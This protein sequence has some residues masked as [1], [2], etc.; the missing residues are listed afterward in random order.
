VANETQDTP[1]EHDS[2]DDPENYVGA[3]FEQAP[4]WSTPKVV[5]LVAVVAVLG[6]V[7]ALMLQPRFDTPAQD[8]AD[9]GFLQDMIDHHE[10]AVQLGLVASDSATDHTVKHFGIEAIV[11]QQYEVGYM[12]SLLEDWGY[13]TGDADR[14]AMAWMG[15]PTSVEQMPGMAS[16]QEMA[17][18]RKSTG[19]DVDIT[20]MRLMIAHHRGGVHMA[21]DA[22]ANATDERV[23]ALAARMAKNQRAEIAEYEA[24]AEKLGF[25]L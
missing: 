7:L 11:A 18:F 10:Q 19:S 17:E 6:V 12:T 5:G 2:S 16:T 15:M 13:G 22:M 23:R 1:V 4:F 9:V 14:D 25:V 21:E 3:E 24:R 8:S 20:F